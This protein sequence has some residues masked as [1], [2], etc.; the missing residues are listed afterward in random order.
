MTNS[1]TSI[2]NSVTVSIDINPENFPKTS[3]IPFESQIK[4][5]YVFKEEKGR[6]GIGKVLIAFD[7]IFGRDVAIKELIKFNSTNKIVPEDKQNFTEM[8]FLKEAMVTG[9]LEHPGIVPVYEIGKRENGT[10]YYTMRLV[11]GETLSKKIK[12]CQTIEE[13]LELLPHFRDICNTIAYSHSRKVIHRDIKPDNIMIGKFGETIVLDW[14]LAKI[15]GE[16]EQTSYK[17]QDDINLL[18]LYTGTTFKGKAFGTPAYM[19]P[20]QA[21]GDSDKIDERSDIYSLGAVLY[22]ILTGTP[23]FSGKTVKN[24]LEQV[25]SGIIIPIIEKIEDAPLDLCAI[26]EKA[27]QKDP[28]DRYPTVAEMID[29]INHFMSGKRVRAYEYT[30]F[31][32][33]KKFVTRNRTYSVIFLSV[34]LFFII[35]SVFIFNSYRN[36]LKNERIAHLNLAMGYQEYAEKLLKEKRYS[37]SAIFSAAALFHNPFN[38]KSPWNATFQFSKFKSS[39]NLMVHSKSTLYS[40]HVLDNH[41]FIKNLYKFDFPVKVLKVSPN[42]KY[43]AIANKKYKILIFNSKFKKIKTLK[44]HKDEITSLNFSPDSNLL[45]SGSR[46]KTVKIW[47]MTS[48]NG[49]KSY[50]GL[51]GEVYAVAFKNNSEFAFASSDNK[52][53]LINLQQNKES[54]IIPVNN[55]IKTLKFSSNGKVLILGDTLGNIKIWQKNNLFTI[56]AHK[57]SIV[58]IEFLNKDT[59]FVSASYD[60][61]VKLWNLKTLKPLAQ[62]KNWDAFYSLAVSKNNKFIAAGSRDSTIKLWNLKSGKITTLRNHEQS[63]FGIAFVNNGK[64]LIS[65]GEDKLLKLWKL[66]TYPE[67]VS[68][69]GHTSYIPS[70]AFSFDMKYLISTGWDKTIRLWNTK[71]GNNYLTIKEPF[72]SMSVTFSPY[73]KYFVTGS[74]DGKIRIWNTTTKHIS[75]ILKKHR[76]SIFSVTYSPNGKYLLSSGNDGLVV[77]WNLSNL[78]VKKIFYETGAVYD[79]VFSPDGK[80]IV[81][82]GRSK[83]IVVRNSKTYIIKKVLGLNLDTILSLD[84]SSTNK[85]ASLGENGKVTLWNM[86]TMEKEYTTATTTGNNMV[87]FSKN[88]KYFMTIGKNSVLRNTKNGDIVLKIPLLYSG[89][90]IDFAQNNNYFAISGGSEIRLYPMSFNLCNKKPEQIMLETE[91]NAGKKLEGFKLEPII[92]N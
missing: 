46:D 50:S 47:N 77:L 31:E 22:E 84:Y 5:R 1:K 38:K 26:A 41:A 18:N 25:K 24:V 85:L 33:L 21:N 36:S 42:G 16:N 9:Q 2:K 39:K 86:K 44:G 88:G 45:I 12:A 11:N 40:A 90:S 27:L 28:K 62:M 56:K 6:G 63:V 75:A 34:F 30:S 35:G 49:F 60:K 79:A 3:F 87:R 15:I 55:K 20:E 17:L 82:G 32:L 78:T 64:N 13:R 37:D 67:V 61:T 10:P 59:Q 8:R 69:Y 68:F 23:P 66:N 76:G 73:G 81:Y 43:I 57:E 51:F 19:A 80:Y 65:S 4:N 71:T 29:D 7:K 89:Y 74:S 83:R 14:G 70:L 92:E 58:S 54:L 53:H 48:Q 72:V 91:Q 52:I